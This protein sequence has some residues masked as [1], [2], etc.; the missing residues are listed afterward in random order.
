MRED[1][2]QR[3]GAGGCPG[4]LCGRGRTHSKVVL[5]KCFWIV[6]EEGFAHQLEWRARIVI[7][8]KRKRLEGVEARPTPPYRATAMHTTRDDLIRQVRSCYVTSHYITSRQPKPHTL[9]ATS[10]PPLPPSP[11]PRTAPARPLAPP[12]GRAR[13]REPAPHRSQHP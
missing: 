11:A 4:P 12:A 9:R 3:R 1:R 2:V 10:K 5:H 6:G 8:L 7:T 13:C